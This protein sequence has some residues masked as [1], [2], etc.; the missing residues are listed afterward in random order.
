MGSGA[1]T[2][3]IGLPILVSAFVTVASTTPQNI[4]PPNSSLS[5]EEL[6]TF[7][8][9]DFPPIDLPELVGGDRRRLDLPDYYYD[10]CVFWINAMRSRE[11]LPALQRW[12]DFED[13]SDRGAK[14]DAR[15]G[16][17]HESIKNG[18]GCNFQGY[19]PFAQNTCPHWFLGSDTFES[20]T[21]AMWREKDLL[22]AI[23]DKDNTRRRLGAY[24]HGAS[25]LRCK[26]GK[27]NCAGHYFNLRGGANGYNAFD[28]VACGF[29]AQ[30]NTIWINQNFGS[31][32]KTIQIL[33]N[34]LLPELHQP[35]GFACG[36]DDGTRPASLLVGD[37]QCLELAD[38]FQYNDC[39]GE[40][41]QDYRFHACVAPKCDERFQG[42]C[43]DYTVGRHGEMY[44]DG[45][46]KDICTGD[47]AWPCAK[48]Y[49]INWPVGS[50]VW[51]KPRDVCRKTCQQ[52]AC[53]RKPFEVGFTHVIEDS[54]E[55]GNA[56]N[57]R[58][59]V[60]ETDENADDFLEPPTDDEN[61]ENGD[62]EIVSVP[63]SDELDDEAFVS[64]PETDV[65]KESNTPVSDD[66]N[67]VD[68]PRADDESTVT[69]ENEGSQNAPE[70][71]DDP[72]AGTP[73]DDECSASGNRKSCVGV[74]G[75]Q[76]TRKR[77]CAAFDGDCASLPRGIC[78]KSG[79]CVWNNDSRP[80][81]CELEPA[82]E[83]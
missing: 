18:I 68:P 47:L 8:G 41:R 48:P 7:V 23:D 30:D 42:P 27:P 2:L 50:R 22:E 83:V 54:D 20:C 55:S 80:R 19:E 31:G 29:Y 36:G 63:I 79:G 3:F 9:S 5:F 33:G 56:E 70:L 76:W 21:T 16:K 38:E 24:G 6:L 39:R 43:M 14:F 37:G 75:C 81:A 32:K 61:P 34:L 13:C 82:T 58:N 77:V 45:S 49:A 4:L 51:H 12:R 46:G 69:V 62:E 73:T 44:S 40:Y 64:D 35:Y 52:C 57:E 60:G 17:Y 65:E 15:V 25:K 28:R 71:S 26:N 53:T 10:K 1:S 59:L 66:A 78:V 74:R 67:V 11:G 72:K